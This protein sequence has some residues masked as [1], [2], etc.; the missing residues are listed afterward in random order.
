M[1]G[2]LK[3]KATVPQFLIVAKK[4]NNSHILGIRKTS[5]ILGTKEGLWLSKTGVQAQER[6]CTQNKWLDRIKRSLN[7]H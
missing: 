6:H 5:L 2:E 4:L 1:F 3:Q 7:G